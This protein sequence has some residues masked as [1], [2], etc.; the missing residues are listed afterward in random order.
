MVMIKFS[1]IQLILLSILVDVSTDAFVT[2]SHSS[3][4][5]QNSKRNALDIV[6][7]VDAFYHT[8]PYAAAFLTCSVKASAADWV[9]QSQSQTNEDDA[10]ASI[11]GGQSTEAKFVKVV[12]SGSQSAEP[13]ESKYWD[14]NRNLAFWLYGGLYQ[15]MIQEFLYNTVFPAIF[16]ES[17][18]WMTVL[19]QVA[20]DMVVLTPFICLPVAYLVKASI[21]P[22]SSLLQGLQKYVQHVRHEGLL[23]RYW[24]LWT[25]VSILTFG[26]VP[27]HLRIPFIA[28]VSFFWLIILSNVS[29]KNT[30]EAQQTEPQS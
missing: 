14:F 27:H 8:Q 26:V 4:T 15:G 21:A 2:P 20:T 13:L 24:S 5:R 16:G 11:S 10:G 23:L 9:A 1:A 6:T 30:D 25:P 18:S 19:E 12:Q 29:A 28:F 7:T 22:D 3:F 17:T